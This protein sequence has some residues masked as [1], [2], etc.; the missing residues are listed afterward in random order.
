MSLFRVGYLPAP[1]EGAGLRVE[2]EEI[3]VSCAADDLAVFHGGAAIWGEDF[4]GAW[5]PDVFPA[6]P[7]ICGIDRYRVMGGGEIQ[8]AVVNEGTRLCGDSLFRLVQANRA[9]ACY[10][11]GCD[12]VCIYESHAFVIVIGVQPVF[13]AA[14]GFVEFLLSRAG[15]G[16]NRDREG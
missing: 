13:F 5:L 4:F 9:E 16:R 7:A 1:E 11:L 15:L 8:N 6:E 12:L 2:R 3:A 14:S 10:I